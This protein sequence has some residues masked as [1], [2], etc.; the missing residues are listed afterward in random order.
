MEKDGMGD[1]KCIVFNNM[2]ALGECPASAVS[3]LNYCYY[4]AT[5]IFSED[6]MQVDKTD[7][8]RK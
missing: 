4:M 5:Y 6:K 3:H 2:S 1:E 7:L 8:E